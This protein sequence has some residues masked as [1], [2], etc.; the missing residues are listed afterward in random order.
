MLYAA[1][2]TGFTN[3]TADYRIPTAQNQPTLIN[4][5]KLLSYTAGIK[6][7]LLNGRLEVN[8]ELFYYDYTDYLIQTVIIQAG[9]RERQ[10]VL[11]RPEGRQLRRSARRARL[12]HGQFPDPGQLC[13]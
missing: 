9:R 2:Q 5:T 12:G 6:N 3:G 10:C 1:V 8:D 7:R 13:V 11:H 4:A